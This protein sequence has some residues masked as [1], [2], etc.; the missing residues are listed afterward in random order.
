MMHVKSVVD[1][2]TSA[3]EFPDIEEPDQ[4]RVPAFGRDTNYV[5][6][7]DHDVFLYMTATT[8]YIT[9]HVTFEQSCILSILAVSSKHFQ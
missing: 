6:K 7:E 9:L 8:I 2:M 3:S 1:A 4:T 5:A